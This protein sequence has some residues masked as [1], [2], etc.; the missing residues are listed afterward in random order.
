M[1]VI[2]K[3]FGADE[4]ISKTIDTVDRVV[5]EAFY[6]KEEQAADKAKAKERGQAFLLTWL[7]ATSPS[8]LARRVL[9]FL[10]S[11]VF[12]FMIVVAT[13][14]QMAAI[15]VFDPEV[16]DKLTAS[17]ALVDARIMF[18]DRP[19]TWILG[20]YFAPHLIAQAG[21]GIKSLMDKRS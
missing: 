9:A 15:W 3:L 21:K 7:E 1:S 8:R 20:F 6:T 13:C 5:D 10:F 11:G 16:A 14:L 4:V 18:L 17:A 12:L 19:I 2:A